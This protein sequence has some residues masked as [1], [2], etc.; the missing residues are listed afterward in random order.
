LKIL[1]RR[2][3]LK[4]LREFFD[5]AERL[6]ASDSQP[7]TDRLGHFPQLIERKLI[8]MAVQPLQVR[9]G[10][11][12]FF[13]WRGGSCAYANRQNAAYLEAESPPPKYRFA[14]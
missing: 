1:V 9:Q 10:S 6:S 13:T 5:I 7:A 4:R 11:R 2:Y 3:T 12:I 14:S 8:A